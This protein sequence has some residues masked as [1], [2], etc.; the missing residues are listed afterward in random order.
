M[1]KLILQ[2]TKN[3]LGRGRRFKIFID[4]KETGGI[5]A[6]ET[7]EFD[8]PAGPH[9]LQVKFGMVK[10]EIKNFTL[11]DSLT[12]NLRLNKFY[13]VS[14]FTLLLII[15][16]R[17]LTPHERIMNNVTIAYFCLMGAGLLTLL[18]F[19][20]FGRKHFIVIEETDWMK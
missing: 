10:S 14:T 8:L 17:R 19:I 15:I 7:K 4:G 20:T 6:K 12:I 18:Y 13:E 3:F 16:S 9:T 2:R 1:P 11:S 5:S